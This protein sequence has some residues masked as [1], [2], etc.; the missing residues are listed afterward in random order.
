M[1]SIGGRKAL[2][3]C[4]NV[5]K[6]IAIEMICAAQ[7]IDYQRPLQS[8]QILETVHAHIRSSIEHTEVDRVF[9]DDIEKAIKMIESKSIL[10]I[11]HEQTENEKLIF[12]SPYDSL[13]EHY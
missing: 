11:V 12:Q 13:F 10:R 3:V 9:W 6:I 2:S 4:K 8:G 5:E 7:S 1:G